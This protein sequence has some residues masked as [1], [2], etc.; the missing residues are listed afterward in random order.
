MGFQW[1]KSVEY[2]ETFAPIA[3]L[4]VVRLLLVRAFM[5]GMTMDQVEVKNEI[6]KG[7]L[8]K[9]LYMNLSESFVDYPR[10]DYVGLQ[11]KIF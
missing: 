9:T 10:P 5:E 3:T 7:V 4:S 8:D 11:M 6:L 1:R 2:C